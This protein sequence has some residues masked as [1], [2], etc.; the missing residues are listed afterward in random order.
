MVIVDFRVNIKD[1]N[2]R[3]TIEKQNTGTTENGFDKEVWIEYKT[4]W[5]SINNLFG[6]EFY[7]AKAVQAESTVE[8]IVR[9]SKELD[10]LNSEG[11]RVLW[12]TKI[13]NITFIDNIKYG[14]RWLKI[15]AIEVI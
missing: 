9:Y 7:A 4:I 1:L 10:C 12:N 15:R 5:A 3:I 2:K 11:Y 13:Y 14:N 8:F 6:K